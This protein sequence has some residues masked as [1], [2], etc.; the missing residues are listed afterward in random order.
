MPKDVGVVLK[1]GKVL[2]RSM[3]GDRSSRSA[4]HIAAAIAVVAT[5]RGGTR[6]ELKMVR[7]TRRELVCG[8]TAAVEKAPKPGF[9]V[10]VDERATRFGD[11]YGARADGGG[12][13]GPFILRNR[14]RVV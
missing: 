1:H 6:L 8:E 10:S 9:I 3:L 2:A 14:R 12:V 7:V 5:G 13:P 4:V 11:Q